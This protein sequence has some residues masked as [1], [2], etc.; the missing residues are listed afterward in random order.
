MSE[1][2]VSYRE[3]VKLS[4]LKEEA[5]SQLI[6]DS[7]D[8][9]LGNSLLSFDDHRESDDSNVSEGIDSTLIVQQTKAFDNHLA[10]RFRRLI[11]VVNRLSE[12]DEVKNEAFED[13]GK[14]STCESAV[15]EE[16]VPSTNLAVGVEEL[17]RDL[18]KLQ[19]KYFNVQKLLES[20]KLSLKKAE[21]EENEL[22]Q[23][24]VNIQD[25][26]KERVDRFQKNRTPERCCTLF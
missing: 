15:E 19:K 12:V 1:G 16:T 6:S 5:E 25:F 13:Y 11:T 22:N 8:E 3:E 2:L 17:M 14:K 23:R 26:F 24:V 9:S 21:E 4:H 18:G 20:T 7:I 10:N